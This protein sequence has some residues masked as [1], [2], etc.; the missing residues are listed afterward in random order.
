M[1]SVLLC[2]QKHVA[3]VLP[4]RPNHPSSQNCC[5]ILKM[6]EAFS[7]SWSGIMYN[8]DRHRSVSIGHCLTY[9]VFMPHWLYR[10]ITGT[11]SRSFKPRQTWHL[12]IY[13]TVPSWADHAEIETICPHRVEGPNDCSKKKIHL[14]RGK[15]TR[16]LCCDPGQSDDWL[17][18][19]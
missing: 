5:T 13:S 12:S 17:A 6:G 3:P 15:N 19:D 8:I 1:I 10:R 4:L 16:S 2:W 11:E 7:T 9:S 18:S 14:M